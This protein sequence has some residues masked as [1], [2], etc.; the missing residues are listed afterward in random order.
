MRVA[1]ESGHSGM[2]GALR[3][4]RPSSQLIK[5]SGS[6]NI[7]VMS[8]LHIQSVCSRFDDPGFATLAIAASRRAD[9]MGLLYRQIACLNDTALDRIGT[10][11]T[12]AGIGRTVPAEHCPLSGAAPDRLSALP[13]TTIEALG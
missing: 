13:E 1:P 9:A 7:R 3:T 10:A 11:V 8:N 6:D 5:S 2:S 12:E 4:G